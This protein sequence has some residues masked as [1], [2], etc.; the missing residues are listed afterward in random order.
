MLIVSAGIISAGALARLSNRS[1]V[2]MFCDFPSSLSLFVASTRQKVVDLGFCAM[3][4][5]VFDVPICEQCLNY[6][7]KCLELLGIVPHY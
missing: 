1:I 5:S 7:E 6:G 2:S 3:S 4:I